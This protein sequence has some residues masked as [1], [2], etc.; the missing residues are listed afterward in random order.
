MTVPIRVLLVDDDPL[1]RQALSWLVESAEDVEI[2]AEATDGGA[3]VEAAL[4]HHPAVVLMDLRLP[5]VDGI[6]ATTRIRAL[7]HPPEVVALTTWDVDDAVVRALDAGASGFLLKSSAPEEILQAVRAVVSGDA[8]LSPRSTR[9][10]LDQRRL[11]VS[12][13][14]RRRAREL[15]A[16]LSRRERDVAAQLVLGHTNAEV[17][18]A[19][20]ISE[21]TVKAHLASIQTKL[22]VDNRTAI[23]VTAD[24]ADLRPPEMM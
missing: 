22:G 11:D 1:V 8:V 15:V 18:A 6:T 16:T 24:R 17:A 3:A 5:T 19:L 12:A 13:G 23:A 4:L 10:L 20:F 21:G 7:P 14:L 2:V 9:R